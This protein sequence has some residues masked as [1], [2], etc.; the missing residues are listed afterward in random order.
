MRGQPDATLAA[1]ICE[2][3]ASRRLSFKQFGT[4]IGVSKATAFR[5]ARGVI[6]IPAERLPLIA[7]AL[8]CSIADLMSADDPPSAFHINGQH[9]MLGE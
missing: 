7:S 8:G 6:H 2:L 5:Y 3:Q 4:A 1:H 9:H